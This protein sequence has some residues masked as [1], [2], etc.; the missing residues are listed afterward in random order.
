NLNALY[1]APLDYELWRWLDH[2]SPIASRLYEFLIIN[3]YSRTPVLRINYE[4]LAQF[5]PIKTE[6]YRSSAE[7]QLEPA[8]RLLAVSNVIEAA[9][10]TDSRRGIGQLHIHRGSKLSAPRE[11]VTLPLDLTEEEFTGAIEVKELRD[12]KPP[13]WDIVAEF[14]A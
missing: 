8:F 5:L 1:T 3:F 12:R 11:Q 6:P 4:K 2:Q 13:E 14:Y 7:R 9:T 10:W